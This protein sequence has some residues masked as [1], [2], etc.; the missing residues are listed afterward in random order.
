[1]LG[2]CNDSPVGMRILHFDKRGTGMSDR[3]SRPPSLET[4][5][6]DI[7]AVMDKAGVE[8]AALFAWG[9]GGPPLAAFFAAAHPERTVALCINPHIHL[10]RS[11]GM[12]RERRGADGLRSCLVRQ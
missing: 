7:R 6:D 1:M 2:S 11:V 12:L 9:D 5:M 10:R 4:R 3:F 8:R